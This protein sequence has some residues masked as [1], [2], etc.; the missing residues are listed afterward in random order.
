MFLNRL[1]NLKGIKLIYK[2]SLVFIELLIGLSRAPK[3][4]H[5]RIKPPKIIIVIFHANLS[6]RKVVIGAN[7]NP[8]RPKFKRNCHTKLF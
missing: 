4:Q 1:N 6:I 8:P 7:A 5:C 3:T 2:I